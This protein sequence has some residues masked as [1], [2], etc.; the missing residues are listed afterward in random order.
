M[1]TVLSLASS[2]NA[3]YL[4]EVVKGHEERT[5]R[6]STASLASPRRGLPAIAGLHL[7]APGSWYYP[8]RENPQAT[9][10]RELLH[11]R[12]D[13]SLRLFDSKTRRCSGRSARGSTIGCRTGTACAGNSTTWPPWCRRRDQVRVPAHLVHP[14]P[15]STGTALRHEG[16]GAEAV[17]TGE[18]HQPGAGG[19]RHDPSADRGDPS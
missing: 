15:C 14:P 7:Y 1:K 2:L 5:G 13:R 3:G 19:Q 16:A 18:L 6:R 17:G 8:T 4:D 12:A 9:R 10:R 11:D